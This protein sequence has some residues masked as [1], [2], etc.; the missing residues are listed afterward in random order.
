M[1][2]QSPRLYHAPGFID[3][4]LRIAFN[5]FQDLVTHNVMKLVIGKR[6]MQDTGV[7]IINLRD[8]RIVKLEERTQA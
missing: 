2:R 5:V 7:R 3:G 1:Y 8:L 6:K 4:R